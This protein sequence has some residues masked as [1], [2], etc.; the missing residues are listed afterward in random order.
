MENRHAGMFKPGQSGNPNG[1][2]KVA[3]TI[4]DKA[5]EHTEA[6]INTLVE[7]MND[8]KSTKAARIQASLALLDRGW[9]KPPQYNESE[10]RM[11]SLAN[12]EPTVSPMDLEERINLLTEGILETSKEEDRNLFQACLK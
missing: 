12:S 7:I 8:P 1:R 6:A 4:R 11:G 9:G 5:R 10:I 2:P 3:I